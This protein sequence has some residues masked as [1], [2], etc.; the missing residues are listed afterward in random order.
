[1][2]IR[3]LEI[4]DKDPLEV[5][6]VADAI[7]R[8]EFKPCSNMFPHAN[9]KILNDEIV[10]IHSSGLVG[11]PE[12]FK[13]NA[14]VCLPRVFGDVGGRS[15]TSWERCSPDVSVEGP[16]SRALRAGTPV[17]RSATAPGA[18]FAAPFD[19]PAGTCVAC[20]YRRLAGVIIMPDLMPVVDDAVGILV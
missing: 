8:E 9:G 17:V 1:M 7:A 16:W 15:E 11:E 14:W 10:I 20:S 3:P 12:V 18:C 5:R 4:S 19:G 6:P 2:D 13:P